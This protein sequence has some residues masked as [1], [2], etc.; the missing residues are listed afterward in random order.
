[1]TTGKEDDDVI[2]D[3][4]TDDD[5]EEEEEEEV[6]LPV[7]TSHCKRFL[8]LAV[9]IRHIRNTASSSSNARR[10]EADT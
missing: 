6:A 1:M 8:I 7:P 4:V 3:D 9:E 2:D 10:Q 5:E